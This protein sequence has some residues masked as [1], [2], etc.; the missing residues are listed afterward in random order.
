MK[1]ICKECNFIFVK[2]PKVNGD[3]LV[4]KQCFGCGCLD[5]KVY[6]F[7][8]VGLRSDVMKLPEFDEELNEEYLEGLRQIRIQ[9]YKE[10]REQSRNE[11]FR[12]Y[13]K[14]LNSKKW[15]LKREKVLERDNYLCQACLTREATQ[16]HH[17]SYEFIYDEPLFDLTSVC[18]ECHKKI[19]NLRDK[20]NKESF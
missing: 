9:E 20:Q 6:K 19:H 1:N 12:E 14:Y 2:K 15:S 7:S 10:T 11:F 5:N 17:L 4:R 13:S 16:V 18:T 3:Y 8:D